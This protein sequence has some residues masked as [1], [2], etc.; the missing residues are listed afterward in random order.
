MPGEQLET[1]RASTAQPQQP[2][3]QH[4]GKGRP[5]HPGNTLHFHN[6]PPAQPR[7][8]RT[9]S[10]TTN[11]KSGVTE[12]THCPV[13]HLRNLVAASGQHWMAWQGGLQARPLQT[14]TDDCAPKQRELRSLDFRDL[15][16]QGLQHQTSK[17]FPCSSKAQRGMPSTFKHS[18]FS[19]KPLHT[20]L[21]KRTK[22]RLS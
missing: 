20:L 1:W 7:Y 14:S 15:G 21:N 4:K 3:A 19:Q 11:A 17:R 9:C 16:F 6:H 13:L 5:R 18:L 12:N 8:L 22:T 2:R 10:E